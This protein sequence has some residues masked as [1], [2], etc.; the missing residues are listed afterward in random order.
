MTTF[1]TPT[2][3]RSPQRFPRGFTLI[4]LLTVI[5]IIGILAAIIIPTVGKVRRTAREAQATSNI[6]Q[7]ALAL[8]TSANEYK[9][10]VPSK[11]E[12]I[13]E[14]GAN[15]NWYDLLQ[16]NMSGNTQSRSDI[17]LNPLTNYDP[18]ADFPNA[19]PNSQWAPNAYVMPENQAMIDA[20][21]SGGGRLTLANA[22]ASRVML[23]S[24][25]PGQRSFGGVAQS[26]FLLFW[27]QTSVYMNRNNINRVIPLTLPGMNGSDPAIPNGAP[28]GIGY[29][30]GGTSYNAALFAFLDGHTSR[31]Q[32]GTITFG[33]IYQK[34]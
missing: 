20:M 3:S 19:V 23:L 9:G 7:T 30:L 29:D 8:I 21:A 31:V 6:R 2:L 34:N 18:S 1:P 15:F 5:A 22:P 27:G 32:K 13:S 14:L 28:G 17:H 25:S 11:A 33:Q 4:E 24:S 12:A 26:L 10:R 16:K